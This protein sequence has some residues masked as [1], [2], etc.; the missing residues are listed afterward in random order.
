MGF[1]QLVPRFLN[2][3]LKT[4]TNTQ[5]HILFFKDKHYNSA[6]SWNFYTQFWFIVKLF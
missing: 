4:E 1:T 5:N 2:F 6:I 3:Q